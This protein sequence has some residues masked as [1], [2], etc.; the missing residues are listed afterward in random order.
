MS[1]SLDLSRANVRTLLASVI[2]VH[3]DDQ[4]ADDMELARL[5]CSLVKE[6]L[7]DGCPVQTLVR[8]PFVLV[9]RAA[10]AGGEPRSQAGATP[11]VERGH[12]RAQSHDTEC[13]KKRMRSKPVEVFFVIDDW[14][15]VPRG[16]TKPVLAAAFQDL[17]V[18]I[19]MYTSP[20]G[21]AK[22]F[23]WTDQQDRV[24]ETAHAALRASSR[25]N[26]DVVEHIKR[27]GNDPQLSPAV[28]RVL[29]SVKASEA[30]PGLDADGE[31]AKGDGS[32]EDENDFAPQQ[33]PRCVEATMAPAGGALENDSEEAQ[34]DGVD[35]IRE[36]HPDDDGAA[37]GAGGSGT[38]VQDAL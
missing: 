34:V 7:V 18:P 6:I 16:L 11:G 27:H 22:R 23:R 35:A 2:A 12:K 26:V 32:E 19:E 33:P 8:L 38:E 1:L 20:N 37:K 21:G 14:G 9:Q 17:G 4:R 15:P 25:C 31:D 13:V 5:D 30:L 29:S 3:P 28:F 24:L 36:I 10:D